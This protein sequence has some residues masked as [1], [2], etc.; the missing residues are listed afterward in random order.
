MVVSGLGLR[1]GCIAGALETDATDSHVHF[2]Q[3]ARDNM[4]RQLYIQVT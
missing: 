1:V 4:F 2:N 3:H